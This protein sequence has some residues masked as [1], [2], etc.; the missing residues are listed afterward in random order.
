[1]RLAM[2]GEQPLPTEG[3]LLNLF[4]EVLDCIAPARKERATGGL[5]LVGNTF[6]TYIHPPVAGEVGGGELDYAQELAG[7][8]GHGPGNPEALVWLAT[9]QRV[10]MLDDRIPAGVPGL[11][12]LLFRLLERAEGLALLAVHGASYLHRLALRLVASRLG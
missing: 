6:L 9:G 4:Q 1:M 10:R 12:R 2:S 7:Q 3:R 11:R 8:G 5:F